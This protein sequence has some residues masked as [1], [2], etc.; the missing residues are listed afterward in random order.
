MVSIHLIYYHIQN[1]LRK[2]PQWYIN[3]TDP[4]LWFIVCMHCHIALFSPTTVQC[5]FSALLYVHTW[6]HAFI[7]Y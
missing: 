2:W 1:L 7:Q 6:A 5:E 3:S 4:N